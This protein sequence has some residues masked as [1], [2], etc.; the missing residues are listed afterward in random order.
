[1]VEEGK[2]IARHAVVEY[3]EGSS[4][5]WQSSSV[6]IASASGGKDVNLTSLSES[7]PNP[8]EDSLCQETNYSLERFFVLLSAFQ[9]LA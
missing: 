2:A 7:A 4:S 9:V 6:G 5:T 8:Y 1:M 3:E